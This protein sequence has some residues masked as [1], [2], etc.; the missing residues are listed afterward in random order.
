MLLLR[1]Q[2]ERKQ[3]F[4][5]LVTDGVPTPVMWSSSGKESDMMEASQRLIIV[6]KSIL[7]KFPVALCVRLATDDE[8]I[9][10]F[11]NELDE[12]EEFA[13]DVL[14]DIAGEAKEIRRVGNDFLAY[15]PVLQTFREAGNTQ[16][17]YDVLDE[18]AVSTKQ[19]THLVNCLTGIPCPFATQTD[20]E[21]VES[22]LCTVER[23]VK[24]EQ[25]LSWNVR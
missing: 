6:I 4:L 20:N 19:A 11:W 9:V 15:G 7:S 16:R 2:L 5:V 1:L 13:L 25:F 8:H 24:Q 14:D 17:I 22:Y 23:K 10:R 21:H 12:E 3:V 18:K